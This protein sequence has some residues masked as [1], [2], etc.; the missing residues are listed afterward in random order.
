MVRIVA[1]ITLL[2][3]TLWACASERPDNPEASSADEVQRL[4]SSDVPA[5]LQHLI[6]LAERW[7]F[8]DDVDRTTK[9]DGATPAEREELRAALAPHQAQITAWLDSFGQGVMSDEAAAFMYMQ[10]ALQ[11]MPAGSA[12]Q[13][14]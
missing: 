9:V 1:A 2:A 5:H 6:P 14:E 8:G 7:G 3:A 11:E 4:D 13:P 10:L 12:R